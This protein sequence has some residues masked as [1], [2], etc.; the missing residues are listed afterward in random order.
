MIAPTQ[1]IM[2]CVLVLFDCFSVPYSLMAHNAPAYAKHL[3]I[4]MDAVHED[5]VV[6]GVCFVFAFALSNGE[7]WKT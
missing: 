4:Q 1:K 3:F 2:D 5:D 6:S 7:K